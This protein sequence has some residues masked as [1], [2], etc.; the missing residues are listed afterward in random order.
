MSGL[1]ISRNVGESVMVGECLVTVEK[2]KGKTVH[3]IF[4]APRSLPIHR[5]KADESEKP[6]SCKCELRGHVEP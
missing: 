4:Q 1:K 6:I 3:L 5:V 2:I